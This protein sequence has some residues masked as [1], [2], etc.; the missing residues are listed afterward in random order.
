[1]GLR[2]QLGHGVCENCPHPSPRQ[3][4]FVVVA[5]NGHHSISLDWCGCPGA[6]DRFEQLLDVGWWPATPTDPET[7]FTMTGLR[8]FHIL[9]LQGKLPPTDY[10]RSLEQ[11]TNGHG[12]ALCPVSFSLFSDPRGLTLRQNRLPGFM[13][14]I[15]E[16]R[17]IKM[18]K[19]AG[20]GHDV[21]GIAGTSAGSLALQCRACPVPGI[22]LPDNWESMPDGEKYVSHLVL[23]YFV[24]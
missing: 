18:C 16:W 12:L 11:L 19:R 3:V 9:N 5:E 1:M 7:A 10:Y 2:Y 8:T 22:N 14:A 4:D 23:G 6:K 13:L 24:R 15:R 20:R 21:T 17:H